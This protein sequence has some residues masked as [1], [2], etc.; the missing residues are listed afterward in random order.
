MSQGVGTSQVAHFTG[1]SEDE[2]DQKK[3]AETHRH[4]LPI[5]VV[6][7]LLVDGIVEAN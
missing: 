7:S 1:E 6:A 2:E 4:L 3:S 5:A